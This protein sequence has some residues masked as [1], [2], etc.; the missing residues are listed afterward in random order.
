MLV[1]FDADVL[2]LVLNPSLEPPVDPATGTQIERTKERLEYLIAECEREK[3]RIIVPSPALSEFLVIAEESGP[4]YLSEID[5]QSMFSI[6]PFDTR[7]AIEAAAL[8][9]SAIAKGNKKSGATGVWQ[10]VKT[11]R[12]IVAIAKVLGI[13]R[14]YSNDS[15]MHNIASDSGIEVIAVWQ[16]PLPPSEQP[17]LFHDNE[18]DAKQ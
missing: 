14:I 17:T 7:A 8:T 10:A 16:L 15:D 6:E 2:S 18:E 13:T 12:Q 5:R 11:D 1:A 3:T 4:D 9:R